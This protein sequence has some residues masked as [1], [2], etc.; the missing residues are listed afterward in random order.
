MMDTMGTAL[1]TDHGCVIF[2]IVTSATA[3]MFS[4]LG[5]GTTHRTHSDIRHQLK[6]LS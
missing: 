2:A 4:V 3:L 5:L 1:L 6:G